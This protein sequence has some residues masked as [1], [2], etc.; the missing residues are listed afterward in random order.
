[1]NYIMEEWFRQQKRECLKEF[2]EKKFND[3]VEI[4]FIKKGLKYYNKLDYQ[5]WSKDKVI[6]RFYMINQDI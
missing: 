6:E 1:M 5:E 3:F 2:N 4:N